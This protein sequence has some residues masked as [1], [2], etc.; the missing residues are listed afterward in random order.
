M[1]ICDDGLVDDLWLKRELASWRAAKETDER[2]PSWKWWQSQDADKETAMGADARLSSHA[3]QQHV[4]DELQAANAFDRIS[5]TAKGQAVLR[6]F[7]AYLG[8]DTFRR[9]RAPL[10]KRRRFQRQ[11]RGS[12]ECA[13][14]RQRA[15][16]G[17]IAA[18]WTEQAGFPLVTVAASCDGDNRRSVSLQQSRFL[19]RGADPRHRT[20]VSRCSTIGINGK[21]RRCC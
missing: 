15:A 8:A 20:G 6:M 10:I 14:R 13:Q 21:P 16:I 11:Q 9:R 3:I 17:D 5:P 1:A 19:L 12:V 18:N 4:V 2:N 7:E